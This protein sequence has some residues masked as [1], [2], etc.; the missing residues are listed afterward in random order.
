[1]VAAVGAA[2]TL[3]GPDFWSIDAKLWDGDESRSCW[4]RLR[5]SHLPQVQ[6]VRVYQGWLSA[7]SSVNS[8]H[9]QGNGATSARN[10]QEDKGD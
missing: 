8:I 9:S 10:L 5:G 2:V 7:S 4:E 1:V 3:R 6:C